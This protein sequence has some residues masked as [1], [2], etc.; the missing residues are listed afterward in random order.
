MA[1]EKWAAGP[2]KNPYFDAE[3]NVVRPLPW[4]RIGKTVG[5]L[6]LLGTMF[7]VIFW[8]PILRLAKIEISGTQYLNTAAV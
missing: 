8:T 3:K 2:Y 5:A 4:K 7:S 1:K 6:L